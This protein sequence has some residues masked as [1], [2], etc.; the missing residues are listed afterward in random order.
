[1]CGL[2]YKRWDQRKNQKLSEDFINV[3]KLLLTFEA[4]TCIIAKSQNIFKNL[5]KYVRIGLFLKQCFLIIW[6][7]WNYV[8]EVYSALITETVGR[9]VFCRRKS[10]G[11]YGMT[12][13]FWFLFSILFV[14]AECNNVF[15]SW[16]RGKIWRNKVFL[17]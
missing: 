11:K 13:R 16:S 1:M 8:V 5:A 3:P 14:K 6:Q 12:K 15:S 7:Q 17:P 9:Y 4:S 10:G 2:V